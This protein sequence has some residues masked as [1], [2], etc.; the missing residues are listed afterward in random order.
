VSEDGVHAVHT[1]TSLEQE[2][3]GIAIGFDNQGQGTKGLRNVRGVVA[4]A[5]LVVDE[6]WPWGRKSVLVGE[7]LIGEEQTFLVPDIERLQ[8]KTARAVSRRDFDMGRM[9]VL[10]GSQ[11][12]PDSGCHR[13]RD[14]VDTV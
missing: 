9:P 6:H 10:R 14:A 1:N 11:R 7:G 12:V 2:G 3:A 4:F 8:A 5:R 13:E